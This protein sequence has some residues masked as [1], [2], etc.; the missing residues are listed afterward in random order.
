MAES[1]QNSNSSRIAAILSDA[2]ATRFNSPQMKA[3]VRIKDVYPK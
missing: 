2:Q 1:I 3:Q